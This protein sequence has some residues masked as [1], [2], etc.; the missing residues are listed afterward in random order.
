MM[1]TRFRTIADRTRLASRTIALAALSGSAL[2]LGGCG[3]GAPEGGSPMAEA[4]KAPT[5]DAAPTPSPVGET[6]TARRSSPSAPE[7]L[8][9]SLDPDVTPSGGGLDPLFLEGH[10]EGTITGETTTFG[11]LSP[12][13][14]PELPTPPAHIG[15][16]PATGLRGEAE[17]A[18]DGAVGGVR[19]AVG[20]F[21]DE[22][23]RGIRGEVDQTIG[24]VRS[25]VQGTI[26]DV[27]GEA[28]QAAEDLRGEVGGVVGE[29]KGQ[30]NQAIEGARDGVRSAV[31]GVRNQVSGEA[32][33]AREGLRKSAQELRGQLLNDL[34]GPP[35]PPAN[36]AP[37]ADPAP[38]KP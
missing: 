19:S 35:A 20:S 8:R 27:K 22:A 5:A 9:A 1:R 30:A 25:E 37:T 7:P 23:A 15:P 6:S 3:S 13:A 28:R 14:L 21:A 10:L 29:V 17:Q 16:A 31:G 11:D 24:E 38:P 36:P 32:Q 12:P 34:I 33:R 4:G 18:I 2:L 26:L